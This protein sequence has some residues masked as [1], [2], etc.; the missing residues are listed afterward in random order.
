MRDDLLIHLLKQSLI[1]TAMI[2]APVLLTIMVVGLLISILQVA[3]QIQEMTLTFIPK[4][5]V[6]V[7]VLLVT[8]G[9]MLHQL[10]QFAKQLYI[11]A[12]TL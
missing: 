4:L 10:S 7:M 6:T 5:I 9:W 2:G 11:Q 3:T 8:G 12:G 1:T